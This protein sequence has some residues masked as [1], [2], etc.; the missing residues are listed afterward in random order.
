MNRRQAKKRRKKEMEKF[1]KS[2]DTLVKCT[3]ELGEFLS[4][5]V[6][7]GMPVPKESEEQDE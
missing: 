4:R 7:D 3:R 1:E 2:L 6:A 5:W